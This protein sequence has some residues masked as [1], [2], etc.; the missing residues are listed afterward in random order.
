M[1]RLLSQ[2]VA[3]TG[4]D[5]NSSCKPWQIQERTT[6]VVYREFHEQVY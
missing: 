3:M 1:V 5:L 4:A 6:E 2:A